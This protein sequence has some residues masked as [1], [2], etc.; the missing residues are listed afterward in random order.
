[1]VLNGPRVQDMVYR[2]A[3]IEQVRLRHRDCHR[4]GVLYLRT[5]S[6]SCPV[7]SA[8]GFI[9]ITLCWRTTNGSALEAT[10]YIL[11]STGGFV[12]E[13][14]G[15]GLWWRFVVEILRC[16]H[17]SSRSMFGPCRCRP[18]SEYPSLGIGVTGYSSPLPSS[19]SSESICADGQDHRAPMPRNRRVYWRSF[20]PK[21]TFHIMFDFA[22]PVF[23]FCLGERREMRHAP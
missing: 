4:L 18:Y 15:G 12:V 17:Y 21:R 3:G 11:G 22:R 1:M 19:N 7:P 8:W 14:Y 20:G 23:F 5:R 13:V 6:S 16:A 2:Q 10:P 9:S